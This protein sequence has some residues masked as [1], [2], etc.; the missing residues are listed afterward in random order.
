MKK[1]LASLLVTLMFLLP[2]SVN[3]T[4]TIRDYAAARHSRFYT[5]SD[6]NFIGALYDFSGVG[7]SNY[8]TGYWATLVSDNYF[9]SAAHYHPAIGQTVTFYATNDPGGASYTYTIAGG[10][11]IEST[12]LWVGWFNTAVDASIERYPILTLPDNADYTG[13]VLYNYGKQDIVGRNV[14]YKVSLGATTESIGEVAWYDYDNN[15]SPSVGGDETVLQYYDS[16]A[17]SFVVYNSSLALVGIH[18]LSDRST[19]SGDTLV[20]EYYDQINTVLDAKDQSMVAV[21]EP[22]LQWY[23]MIIVC[24]LWLNRRRRSSP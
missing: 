23:A 5:G 10:T 14:V 12:D 16:G 4:M 2:A 21:P 20:P 19:I 6:K 7:Y 17:P 18:W 3:G 22:D 13:L 15:D 8:G 1:F 11:K 9:I 24:S